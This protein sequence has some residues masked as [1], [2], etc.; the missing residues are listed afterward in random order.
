[1]IRKV[2]LPDGWE[3]KVRDALSGV[4]PEVGNASLRPLGAGLDNVTLLLDGQIVLRLPKNADGAESVER[5]ARLLPE[6]ALDLAI[7]RFLFTAPNP[8]GPG[9]FCGY[10][11][12]PGEVLAPEQ[13]HARGLVDRPG[14]VGQVAAALDAV[15]A[16]PV[17]TAEDLGVPVWDLREDFADDLDPIRQEVLPRLETME[18]RALLVA[19]EGYLEDDANFAYRP[20]L[21]H[22]D[23]SLDHLLVTGE[24]ITGLIDFGDTAIADPDYD[25]S[26]LWAEAG[27]EFV[28]RVQAHRDLPY[29]RRLVGKLDFW[30]LAEPALDVVHG[31]EIDEPELVD[32]A[33][34]TLRARLDGGTRW[35]PGGE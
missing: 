23:M 35:G 5:E 2:S 32:E 13:W 4:L 9:S 12:V 16:F 7:P 24:E 6:L 10:R 3:P 29:S 28:C 34:G 14:P 11:L 21:T 1:M 8:L 33:L 25:L 31:L 27:P 18:G 19:W 20:T 30:A 17:E 15:H 22:G 26:Y